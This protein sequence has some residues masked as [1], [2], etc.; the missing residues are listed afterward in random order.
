M[1]FLARTKALIIDLRENHGG[2]PAT[3]ALL[4]SY[5]FGPEPVHLNDIYWRPDNSTGQYWTQPFVVGRRYGGDV[6]VLTSG[7]TFSA[8]EELAYDLQSQ[9]R[10]TIVG[11]VTRGGAHPITIH[12]IDDHFMAMIPSGRAINPVTHTDWEGV[13]V[14]PEVVVPA[15]EALEKARSLALAKLQ[16]K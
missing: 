8:G 7:K 6:Y 16:K 12:R 9:R 13:G 11:E 4:L 5:L 1:A 3:V 14:K 15:A 2:D 10:A